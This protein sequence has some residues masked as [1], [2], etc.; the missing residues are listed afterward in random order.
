MVGC[1]WMVKTPM[2]RIY[3]VSLKQ[4]KLLVLKALSILSVDDI[5]KSALYEGFVDFFLFDINLMNMS[6][7][8]HTILESWPWKTFEDFQSSLA[9]ANS[10]LNGEDSATS[11]ASRRLASL[12]AWIKGSG[13]PSSNA[14]SENGAGTATSPNEAQTASGEDLTSKVKRVIF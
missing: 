1:V 2:I 3:D 9:R 13:Q 14:N 4:Q 12:S 8:L 6:K 5:K 11:S 7:L 10:S